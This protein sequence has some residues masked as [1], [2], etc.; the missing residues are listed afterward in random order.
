MRHEIVP[1][2]RVL[3]SEEADEIMAKL[4]M[5]REQLPKISIADPIAQEI[6]ASIGDVIEIRRKSLTAGYTT[7]YRHAIK[8]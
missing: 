8:L 1:E 5:K 3:S 6:D 2:H 7:I 4:R